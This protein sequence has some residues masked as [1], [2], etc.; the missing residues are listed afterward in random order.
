MIFYSVSEDSKENKKASQSKS[1]V[2]ATQ[3]TGGGLKNGS[4]TFNTLQN[5]SNGSSSP[6][7]STSKYPYP[8]NGKFYLTIKNLIMEAVYFWDYFFKVVH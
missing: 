6:S 7:I 3:E 5:E 2:D 1:S 4:A 8:L